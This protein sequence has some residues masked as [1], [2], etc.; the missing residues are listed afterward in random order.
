MTEEKAVDKLPPWMARRGSNNEV[1]LDV[2]EEELNRVQT[3]LDEVDKQT[4]PITADRRDTLTELG[5]LVGVDL[6]FTL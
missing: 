2:G 1:L 5:K 6:C 3:E 4:N